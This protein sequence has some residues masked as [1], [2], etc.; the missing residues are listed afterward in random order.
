MNG[1][2]T[3]KGKGLNAVIFL[4]ASSLG[5]AAKGNWPYSVSLGTVCKQLEAKGHQLMLASKI[6]GYVLALGMLACPGYD[7]TQTEENIQKCSMKA[8]FFV[9]GGEN[10]GN[11]NKSSN[12]SKARMNKQK[13]S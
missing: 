3:C 2:S 9:V 7:G 5:L 13:Q 8:F 12:K 4:L 6:K 1:S 10:Q 11:R